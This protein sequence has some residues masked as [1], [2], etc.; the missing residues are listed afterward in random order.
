[1]NCILLDALASGMSTEK[2]NLKNHFKT[3]DDSES[4][5]KIFG[6]K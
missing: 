1:M 3:F 6:A 4:D 5:R 2:N